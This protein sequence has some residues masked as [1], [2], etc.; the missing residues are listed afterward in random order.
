MRDL[1]VM[2]L[3]ICDFTGCQHWEDYTSLM[4]LKEITFTCVL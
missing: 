2:L 3:S 4:G 1:Y